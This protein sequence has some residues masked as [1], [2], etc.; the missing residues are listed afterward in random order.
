VQLRQDK[1]LLYRHDKSNEAAKE[2][3]HSIALFEFPFNSVSIVS[4]DN[5]SLDSLVPGFFFEHLFLEDSNLSTFA[6]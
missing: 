6:T 3:P 1:N 4:R 2:G 5:P